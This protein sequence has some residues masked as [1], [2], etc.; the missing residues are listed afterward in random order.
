L[1]GERGSSWILNKNVCNL[2]ILLPSIAMCTISNERIYIIYNSLIFKN[3]IGNY[4]GTFL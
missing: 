1:E 4:S 2:N 3:N